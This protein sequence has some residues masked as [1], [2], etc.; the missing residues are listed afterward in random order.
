[1]L[2]V[3]GLLVGEQEA[4]AVALLRG[5]QTELGVEQ[6]AGGVLGEHLGDEALELLEVL[7]MSSGAALLG[8]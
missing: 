8:E 1:M 4:F 5:G 3:A 6:D 7:G 2:V